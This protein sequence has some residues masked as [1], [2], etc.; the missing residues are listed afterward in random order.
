[1]ITSPIIHL[2][3]RRSVRRFGDNLD[4]LVVDIPR[5]KFDILQE[6]VLHKEMYG[7]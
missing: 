7:L 4:R 1:M 2:N 6:I 3:I 5:L